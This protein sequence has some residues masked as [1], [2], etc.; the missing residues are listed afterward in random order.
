MPDQIVDRI[1]A[2]IGAKSATLPDVEMARHRFRELYGTLDTKGRRR[3]EAS[4]L[5]TPALLHALGLSPFIHQSLTRYPRFIHRLD[6]PFLSKKID[7]HSLA[8]NVG[9]AVSG[10]NTL[11]SFSSRI[12]VFR[13]YHTLRIALRELSGLGTVTDTMKEMSDLADVVVGACLRFAWQTLTAQVGAPWLVRKGRKTRSRFSVIDLGKLGGEE[14]NFSSDIDIVYLYDSEKGEIDGAPSS[15]PLPNAEFYR[16]LS[17]LLTRLISEKTSHG[18]GFR[19]DLG[20]RPDGQYGDIASSLRSME[21]YYEAWGK[22]WE[23]AVWIKARH[24]AGHAPLTQSLLTTL[25]PFVY[26]KYLDFTAIEEIRDLK[27]KM[28]QENRL[29][30]KGRDDIKLGR[31]GI[32]EIEFFVQALQLIH[33]GKIPRLQCRSTLETLRRLRECGLIQERESGILTDAYLFLRRLEHRI[34]LIHQ[35]Q[36]QT[37]PA[38]EEEQLRLARSLGFTG[39][40]LAPLRSMKDR[41]SAYREAVHQI[42]TD[43]FHAPSTRSTSGVSRDILALFTGDIPPEIARAW[44]EENGFQEPERALA[45]L[46]RLRDGPPSAHYVPKTLTRL[47]RLLPS[48]LQ[49]VISSPDPDMA[50]G[51][52]LSFVEKIGARG[53]FYALLLENPPV[54]KLLTKVFG[55][56]RFLSSHLV[57]HPELLDE[58]IHPEQA[59]II[60]SKELMES[61]LRDML[62]NASGDLELEMDLLRKF[63]N[64]EILRIGMN[65]IYSDMDIQSVTDQLSNVAAVCLTTA[66]QIARRIQLR[67]FSLPDDTRLPFI[68]LGLGKLGGMELNYSSDLD[69]IFLYDDTANGNLP[70]HIDPAEFYGKLAQR[71]ISVMSS[72]TIEGTLYEIDTRLRPSGTFGPIVTSLRSFQTYHQKSAWF[73]ER[74]ALI[75]ARPIAGSRE[76]FLNVES[77]IHE[78][79]YASPLTEHDKNEL[80]KIRG[81]MEVEIGKESHNRFHV[82]CGE[83]G[84]VD[85]EFLI[86]YYQLKNGK[87]DQNVRNPNTLLALKALEEKAIFSDREAQTLRGNYLFLRKFENRLQILE[88]RSSP[89]FDPKAP[90]S[91]QLARRM[92]YRSTKGESAAE[93]LFKD[94]RKITQENRMCFKRHIGDPT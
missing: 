60:K 37:L 23:R 26:R 72:K 19:V 64:A 24:G 63:K 31:G 53:T 21:V 92:G 43:L 17:E 16:R 20:L 54:L 85:I 88:N 75:K 83:G 50:L 33:G 91:A 68:I 89:V 58:L 78:I 56:S 32:R 15:P 46:Q 52:L 71:F 47:N 18:F 80:L 13:L 51:Y 1:I 94:Y 77:L 62:R 74:Q 93:R 86:Q 59:T 48:L 29:R 4:N 6:D 39:S 14:L 79:V 76:M 36:T 49:S 40:S 30:R 42:Y 84:L 28:D 87:H 41:L 34:Q 2:A 45:T 66:Y 67:R 57:Y 27:L 38:D 10:Q 69:L 65:D 22:L 35:R 12:R 44:L 70:S 9:H 55:S 8:L 25:H 82:K 73:W 5:L 7:K 81:Q 3:L 90:G 11:E 61:E